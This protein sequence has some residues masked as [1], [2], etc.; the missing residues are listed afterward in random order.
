MLFTL[1]EVTRLIGCSPLEILIHVVSLL[2]FSILS[3]LKVDGGFNSDLSW[4]V[5]FIPLFAADALNAYFT[6]IIF[7]RF[8]AIKEVKQ[9]GA[10][11][12]DIGRGVG[13]LERRG[14]P[15]QF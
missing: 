10:G 8:Y 2:V 12:L 5:C 13:Q 14:R 4:S 15:L 7:V 11:Y 6:L 9:A 1:K 3:T